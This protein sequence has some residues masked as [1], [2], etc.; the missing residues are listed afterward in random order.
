MKVKGFPL[1]FSCPNCLWS[2][3]IGEWELQ[4]QDSKYYI[5]AECPVCK[6]EIKK[7]VSE[8]FY[9]IVMTEI[10]RKELLEEER[11]RRKQELYEKMKKYGLI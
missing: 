8:K 9:K 4:K 5:I 10:L 1:V 3:G 7:E 6:S 11:R 2:G